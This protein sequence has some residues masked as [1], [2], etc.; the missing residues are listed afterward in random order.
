MS[1]HSCAQ[2][3]RPTSGGVPN[4]AAGQ[5]DCRQQPT[6]SGVSAARPPQTRAVRRTASSPEAKLQ[7]HRTRAGQ[8]WI[9]SCALATVP[10]NERNIPNVRAAHPHYIQEAVCSGAR[11]QCPGR[12]SGASGQLAHTQ[13]GQG[14][15][16]CHRPDSKTRSRPSCPACN[17]D[18]GERAIESEEP[19]QAG[20]PNAGSWSESSR[21]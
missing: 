8:P 11:H 3:C 17:C 20:K 19:S 6:S 1:T 10:A 2:P 16:S 14:Q 5:P 15:H 21:P 4:G 12:Q 9:S 7:H 18:P 13:A